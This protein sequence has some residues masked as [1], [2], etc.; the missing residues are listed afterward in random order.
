LVGGSWRGKSASRGKLSPETMSVSLPVLVAFILHGI[1]YP[2]HKTSVSCDRLTS[3]HYATW[4]PKV[5]L[6][7]SGCPK[8]MQP[9]N[10]RQASRNY[11]SSLSTSVLCKSLMPS[12]LTLTVAT[13]TTSLVEVRLVSDMPRGLL[14][15]EYSF[16]LKIDDDPAPRSTAFAHH[17]RTLQRT[18]PDCQL[19][20]LSCC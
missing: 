20:A 14:T 19:I 9:L 5:P 12:F 3:F 16:A 17:S 2:Q 7:L 13:P 6:K 1:M 4:S 10:P 15:L 11:S 8:S 18:G